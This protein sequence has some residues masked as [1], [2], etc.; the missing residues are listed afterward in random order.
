[1]P[2]HGQKRHASAFCGDFFVIYHIFQK[3]FKKL[4]HSVAFSAIITSK[5][6]AQSSK[7]APRRPQQ[8]TDGVQKGALPKPREAVYPRLGARITS[9]RLSRKRRAIGSDISDVLFAFLHLRS[10]Y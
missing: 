8:V 10:F 3:K 6:E 4:L 1:M 9:A 5:I 2:L 7:V